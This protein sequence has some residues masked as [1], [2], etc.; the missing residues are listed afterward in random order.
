MIGW[1]AEILQRGYDP[2]PDVTAVLSGRVRDPMDMEGLGIEARVQEWLDRFEHLPR[3]RLIMRLCRAAGLSY[4]EGQAKWADP[5]DLA[6]EIA[7][8]QWLS[9]VADR[10]CPDCGLDPELIVDDRGRPLRRTGLVKVEGWHCPSC[11]LMDKAR[12]QRADDTKGNEAEQ[13]SNAYK[14]RFRYREPGDPDV[15]V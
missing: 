4:S 11:D 8:D 2:D 13:A 5:D 6:A 12:R 7:W 15:D 9:I 10:T 1:L 14:L 3:A